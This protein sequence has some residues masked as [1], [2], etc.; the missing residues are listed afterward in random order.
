MTGLEVSDAPQ[1][2]FRGPRDRDTDCVR[3]RTP[4]EIDVG[5][6]VF[7]FIGVRV[8]VDNVLSSTASGGDT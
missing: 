7:G 5:F 1:I 6:G 2:R 3:V 4:R 8:L